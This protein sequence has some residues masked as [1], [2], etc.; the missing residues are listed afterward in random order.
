MLIPTSIRNLLAVLAAGL[1]VG[2]L[3]IATLT[4]CGAAWNF[5]VRLGNPHALLALLIVLGG[6][7]LY[8]SAYLLLVVQGFRTHWVWGVL[9]L[10]V[11]LCALL[12]LIMHPRR[13]RAGLLLYL[14]AVFLFVSAAY[15][16]RGHGGTF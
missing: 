15:M 4:C 10:I 11:P 3:T 9:N 2:L 7:V 13:A 8:Y 12:F 6:I 16:T 14:G 1:L 5:I